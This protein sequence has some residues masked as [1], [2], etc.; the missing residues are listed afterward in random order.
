MDSGGL[1]ILNDTYNANSDS[2]RLAIDAL[3]D[4]PC[5]GKRIAVLG[6][7]L[8]LGAAGDVEHESIGRYIHGSRVDRLYVYGEKARL[9]CRESPGSCQGHFSTHEELL[10]AL[11]EGVHDGDAILFQGS[12]GMK[13]ERV[14]EALINVRTNNR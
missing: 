11:L 1:R 4:L 6:D 3:C 5:E 7:M 14:V 8:E 2:M 9:I 13:L 12:R 10:E